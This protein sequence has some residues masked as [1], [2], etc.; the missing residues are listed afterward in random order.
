M[1]PR[2]AVAR[3]LEGASPKTMARTI[4]KH[5]ECFHR[6]A[7]PRDRQH[8]GLAIPPHK[9]Q[10]PVSDEAPASDSADTKAG[11]LRKTKAAN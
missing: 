5:C 3:I 6:L 7:K 1:K 4:R 9:S 10:T 2:F 11:I 8:P